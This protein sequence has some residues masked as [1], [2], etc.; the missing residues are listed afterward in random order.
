MITKNI[1]VLE[2]DDIKSLL[3]NHI[4]ESDVLDY[5]ESM[6]SDSELT[7]HVSA[8]ANTHGGHIVF[9]VTESGKGGYPITLNGIS[10]K[11]NKERIEQIILSNIFPRLQIKQKIIDNENENKFLILQI[12]DSGNRPHFDNKSQ[13]FYKRFQFESTTM[14]EQE[15]SDMYKNRFHNLQDVQKYLKMTV[16]QFPLKRLYPTHRFITQIL[17]AQ[18]I[19]IPVQLNRNLI[20]VTERNVYDKLN[21]NN[22]DYNPS[23][24]SYA[25]HHGFLP[26]SPSPHQFGIFFDG[27]DEKR[28]LVVHRNGCIQ[29]IQDIGCDKNIERHSGNLNVSFIQFKFLAIK[30]MHVLQFAEDI[31]SQYNYFGDVEILVKLRSNNSAWGLKFSEWD[32]QIFSS[33]RSDPIEGSSPPEYMKTVTIERNYP[34]PY[35]KTNYSQITS[36]IMNE[37]YNHFEIMKCPL[38]DDDGQYIYEKF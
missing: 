31:L 23:G 11:I 27:L 2:Y 20:D 36:S 9:G 5:K 24:Y 4:P 22:I 7:K 15:V 14:Q 19:V 37:V 18:I 34:T 33:P 3:D 21:P 8:F 25:P 1:D 6:I 17:Q 16:N 13:K 29:H 10:E 35:L 12:P 28:S 38:F 30:L 26:G 32:N